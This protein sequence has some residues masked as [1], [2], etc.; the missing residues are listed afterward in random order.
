MM[1]QPIAQEIPSFDAKKDSCFKFT[2]V[3][4]NQVVA[5][6]LVIKNNDTGQTVY[7]QRIESYKFE[8]T[9][10]ANTLINGK[11]YNFYFQTYGVK[12]E[13]S[14][15]SNIILF[16]CYD[17]PIIKITNIPTNGIIN[18]NNF[19]LN[20]LYTQEQN[21]LLDI[22]KIILFDDKNH[23][24][25]ES[26]PIYN[27]EKTPTRFTYELKGLDYNNTYYV[28]VVANTVNKTLIKSPKYSFTVRYSTPQI[29][30]LFEA[31]NNCEE[32]C[33]ELKNNFIIIDTKSN[34]TDLGT[35]IKY[36]HDGKLD[37]TESG[38]FLSY[39]SGFN[40][41]KDFTAK[42]FIENAKIGN[43]IELS[44]YNN[45]VNIDLI[46]YNNCFYLELKAFAKDDIDNAYVIYSDA[47]PSLSKIF[48]W[49]RKE[50][51]LFEIKTKYSDKTKSIIWNNNTTGVY[52]DSN[53]GLYW[54]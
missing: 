3:G 9:L 10:P 32:G 46:K 13:E 47:I 5:N 17:E 34:P 54:R 40:I 36:L 21:E 38:T 8:H 12:N 16:I 53:T 33:V 1:V 48:I 15:I 28:Q 50:N 52:Y 41:A 11:Y 42:F 44:N 14:P 7:N 2:S 20:I 25:F 23:Q 39:I 26:E 24:I 27:T 30:T 37:L 22:S 43:L 4:G 18:G 35:N 6:R 19:I 31:T 45:S 29:N 51:G 49:I